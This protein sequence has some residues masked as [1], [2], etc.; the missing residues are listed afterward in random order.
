MNGMI[1]LGIAIAVVFFIFGLVRRLISLAIGMAA[2]AIV[3]GLLYWFFVM[4]GGA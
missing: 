1:L 3:G 2:V 4:R